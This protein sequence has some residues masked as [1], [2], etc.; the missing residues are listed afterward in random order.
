M[1]PKRYNIKIQGKI[2]WKLVAEYDNSLNDGI[3]THEQTLEKKASCT[4]STFRQAI[5]SE[6]KK[7]IQSG[8]VKAEA[9][10]SYVPVSA[11]VSAEYDSLKEINDLMENT[12]RSQTEEKQVTKSTS[13]RTLLEIGPR[14]R[15][16]LYQQWFSAAGVDLESDVIS[17]NPERGKESKIIDIDVVVEEQEF[18]KDVKVVYSDQASGKP[19]GRVQELSGWNDDMNAGFKGKCVSLVP[20]YTNDVR[21]AAISFEVIIQDNPSGEG[22]S[23]IAKGDGGSFRYLVPY[24]NERNH[25][26]IYE[27][28][29]GCYNESRSA[30]AIRS[31]GYEYSTYNINKGRGGYVLYLLWK[32]K[33][34]YASV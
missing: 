11:S 20:V 2:Y 13:Q 27:L 16:I 14:S 26:K 33:F 7:A 23:D 9:G 21:E 12:I 1:A 29:L 5:D 28:A 15:L 30:E 32:S 6:T 8:A 19:D 34:A 17:T 22:L 24:K 3:I 4:F 31:L 10:A 18:I 25:K